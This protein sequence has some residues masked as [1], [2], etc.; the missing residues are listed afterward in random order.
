VI[1]WL[2]YLLLGVACVA[3]GVYGLTRLFRPPRDKP[4]QAD[5]GDESSYQSAMI[6]Y[7]YSR[8]LPFASPLGI[9]VGLRL[10]LAASQNL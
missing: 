4:V 6:S 7:Y 3:G 5:Y 2:L 8:A 1:G 10:V 9:L